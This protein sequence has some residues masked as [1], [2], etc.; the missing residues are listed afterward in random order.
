MGNA[1][2]E[3]ITIGTGPVRNPV[4]GRATTSDGNDASTAVVS[5][6][7]ADAAFFAA[8]DMQIDDLLKE[9]YS[10]LAA[11]NLDAAKALLEKGFVINAGSHKGF[12][13]A[14]L[15]KIGEMSSA[16]IAVTVNFTYG[17]A[18]YSVTIPGNSQ[19]N[20]AALVDENGYCGFLNLLKYFK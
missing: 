11:G 9:F 6:G 7:D 20:P 5:D 16:G 8:V 2:P 15:E 12:D 17:G 10:L 14:T 1:Q 4:L 19:I 3:S 13:R 18:S